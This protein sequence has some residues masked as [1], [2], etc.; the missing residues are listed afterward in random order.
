VFVPAVGLGTAMTFYMLWF[1]ISGELTA[2]E[3][4]NKSTDHAAAR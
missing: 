3:S 2:R 1:F 4:L